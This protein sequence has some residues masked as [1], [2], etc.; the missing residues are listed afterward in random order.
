MRDVSFDARA[1]DVDLEEQTFSG[2]GPEAHMLELAL[3][4]SLHN[5]LRSF[6]HCSSTVFV[7]IESLTTGQLGIKVPNRV[8]FFEGKIFF[9]KCPFFS[10]TISCD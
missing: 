5:S 9:L 6:A 2:L 7:P 8:L 4:L 1:R 10:A 3:S